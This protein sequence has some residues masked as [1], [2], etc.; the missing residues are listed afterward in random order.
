MLH[1][2]SPNCRKIKKFH[3]QC[4]NPNGTIVLI[5][6]VKSSIVSGNSPFA[7][8]CT[9][10]YAKAEAMKEFL[11]RVMTSHGFVSIRFRSKTGNEKAIPWGSRQVK[12]VCD[13]EGHLRDN[14]TS[15]ARKDPD[16]GSSLEN[17]TMIDSKV[18]SNRERHFRV[19]GFQVLVSCDEHSRGLKS[20]FFATFSCQTMVEGFAA[21]S[22]MLSTRDS[23]RI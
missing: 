12:L 21:L 13:H 3:H 1:S 14:C 20:R 11:L 9:N 16:F 17:G 22:E 23:A 8:H 7:S 19:Q 6:T 15:M 18:F 10:A 2:R 5:Q 4:A